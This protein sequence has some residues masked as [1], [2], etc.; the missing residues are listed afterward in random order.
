MFKIDI[1]HLSERKI[2]YLS[3]A[4]FALG[5]GLRMAVSS[6]MFFVHAA[7]PFVQIPQHLNLES[8]SIYLFDKNVEVE[9]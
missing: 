1:R 6:A 5:I 7:M 2:T 8:M 9:D 4:S 3:H